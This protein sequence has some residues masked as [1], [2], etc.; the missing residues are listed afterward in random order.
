[1]FEVKLFIQEFNILN[2]ISGKFNLTNNH[3][4]FGKFYTTFKGFYVFKISL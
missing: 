1:M 4:Q 2:R 3:T